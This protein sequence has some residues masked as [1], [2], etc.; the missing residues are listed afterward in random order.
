[1]DTLFAPHNTYAAMP[2]SPKEQIALAV[3]PKISGFLSVIGSGW[4]V[5]E[6]LTV[7]EKRHNVYNRLLLAMSFIDVLSSAWFAASTWP[8]PDTA[9]HVYQPIGSQQTCNAQ[10]FFI[11]IGIATPI[12]KYNVYSLLW[13]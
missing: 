3:T 11:Q 6:I 5:V 7:R 13:N 1:M 2:Y 9:Q 8:I 4:I 12:C 10:G